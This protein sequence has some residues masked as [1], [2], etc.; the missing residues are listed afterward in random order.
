MEKHAGR[1]KSGVLETALL[2]LFYSENFSEE[3]PNCDTNPFQPSD[4]QRE[5][6]YAKKAVVVTATNAQAKQCLLLY[7]TLKRDRE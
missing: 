7:I 3:C 4:H 1:A 6:A 5:S 2:I